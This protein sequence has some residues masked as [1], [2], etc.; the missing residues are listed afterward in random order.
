[1]KRTLIALLE[2][3]RAD[4]NDAIV[5]IER[6][7]VDAALTKLA[8]AEARIEAFRTVSAPRKVA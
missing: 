1:M 8:A 5:D 2:H 4:L 7:D 3:L 6:D